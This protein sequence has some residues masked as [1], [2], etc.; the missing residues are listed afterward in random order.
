MIKYITAPSGMVAHTEVST[1]ASQQKQ[2]KHNFLSIS[3]R[4]Q[5]YE[6]YPRL[7][8]RKQ[9]TKILPWFIIPK[10][11]LMLTVHYGNIIRSCF[12]ETPK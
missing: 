4:S 7:L 3:I 1:V 11:L 6:V 9:V 8:N 2:L 5:V 10:V 12:F